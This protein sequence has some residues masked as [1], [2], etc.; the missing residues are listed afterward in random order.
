MQTLKGSVATSASWASVTPV[1]LAAKITH[2]HLVFTYADLAVLPVQRKWTA[3]L[4]SP[5]PQ[6]KLSVVP[7]LLNPGPQMGTED[8]PLTQAVLVILFSSPAGKGH[9]L[10]VLRVHP[11]SHFLIASRY[12]AVSLLNAGALD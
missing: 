12:L 2:L 11:N 4:T 3:A 1:V 7:P 6:G 8:C 10:I 5:C 9:K